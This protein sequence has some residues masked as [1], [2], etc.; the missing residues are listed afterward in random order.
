M[1]HF[2][3]ASS[4]EHFLYRDLSPSIRLAFWRS[5]PK[6][7]TFWNVSHVI[8]YLC[9]IDSE[10]CSLKDIS[11]KVVTLPCLASFGRVHTISLIWKSSVHFLANKSAIIFI[12]DDLKVKR[13][14]RP[15]FTLEF[16]HF[17]QDR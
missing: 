17:N 3:L 7:S 1:I 12:Y 6:H 16:P 4:E 13:P 5:L 8:Q 15:H 2:Y 9:K 10:T 11:H 14:R